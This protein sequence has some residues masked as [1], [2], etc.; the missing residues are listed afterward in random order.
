M[1]YRSFIEVKLD[2][3]DRSLAHKHA[4][5]RTQNIV[6]QF[7][8]QNAPLCHLE[9]NFVGVLGEIAVYKHLGVPYE[10]SES[11]E[12][13]QVDDGDL[14]Y[15]G[16]TYDVKTDAVPNSYYVKLYDGTIKNY[17]KYGCRVFT[18]KHLH[19]LKKYTGGLIFTAISIPDNAK[20]TKIEGKVRDAIYNVKSII[21]I[22][23]TKQ[24]DVTSNH[25]TWFAP[26]DPKSS[27]PTK[28]NSLNYIFHHCDNN[29][30]AEGSAIPTILRPIK[31]IK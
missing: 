20:L 1:L 2:A 8:P 19:H 21:I 18:V 3:S 14:H 26:K 28:Y 4:E 7:V 10:L 22:G 27:S 11:Y 17:E 5:Q 30:H 13:K 15:N 9:S 24:S 25:P 12:D 16:L 23:Y 6:R 31:D 29:M